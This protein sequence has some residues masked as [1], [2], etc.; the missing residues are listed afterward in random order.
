M[1]AP[2]LGPV[3]AAIG[4]LYLGQSVIGGLAFQTLPAVLRQQG[5]G[6]QVIGLFSLMFLPQALKFL[7][8]PAVERLRLRADGRRHS[9]P[10][11]LAGQGI[12][13]LL[14]IVL[15]AGDGDPWFSF[16][17]IAAAMLVAAT[18][19]IACDG[20][21]VE[22]LPPRVRG[23]GNTL[24]VGGAYLGMALGGGLAL[25]LLRHW[26][27]SAAILALAAALAVAAIPLA[28]LREPP[29]VAP[30]AR[31]SLR[32]AWARPLLRDGLRR[33]AMTQT[34][35]RMAMALLPAL[36][37][38]AGLGLG[39]IG[40]LN[41]LGGTTVG[42]A[43]TLAAGALA[44][45][46]GGSE[47]LLR[48]ALVAQAAIFLALGAAAFFAAPAAVLVGLALL[49]GLAAGFAF[50]A[51]YAAMMGWA[52]GPQPGIDFSLLQCA[53]AGLAVVA[54]MAAVS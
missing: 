10:I 16:G 40:W 29:G 4:G 41:G 52:A 23:W 8:A 31:P 27:W 5:Q 17:L 53:D 32:Q 47:A 49:L 18:L 28:L 48:P 24:Q 14:L 50:V 42:L 22:Q 38:D 21:A 30:P 20:F 9:K 37:V 35:L 25:V 45:R 13:V 44:A 19:D 46:A 39:G 43:G 12:A 26:G 51:L 2:R 15:A 1:P 3:L 33:V 6:L 7:W 34:G 54:G 36:L 11:I